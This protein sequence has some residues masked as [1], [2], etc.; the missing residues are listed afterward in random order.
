MA[1]DVFKEISSR[2]HEQVAFFNFPEVGL[3]AIVGI[4]STALGPALGGCR[5]RLYEDE[6]KAI[7]DALRLSEGMSY[8]NS[9]AGMDLGGGKSVIIADPRMQQGRRELFLKFAECLNN[10][11]GRYITAE[12]MGTSVSDV[13]IMREKTKHICGIELSEGGSGDPSPWTARGVFLGIQAALEH[14]FGSADF[15][16]RKITV[17]GVG[18]V[19]YHT[20]KNL[21]EAG[22]EV[23]VTD[24]V[25]E[26]V[27]AVVKEFGVKAVGIEEIYDEEC[28]VYAPCAIGQTVNALTIGRLKCKI[29]AGAANN[30]LINESIYNEIIGKNILYCPDFAVNAGGVINVG[31]EYRPGG[32]NKEW[33]AQK[34][35]QIY[36]TTHKILEESKTRKK[37][38]EVVALEL[39]RERIARGAPQT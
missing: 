27:D 14:V 17:Q 18:H 23:V 22:A 10:L 25:K 24:T 32:W 8:K 37:F 9:L 21:V 29:I 39:A 26:A 33:V 11:M 6:S 19:G 3:K 13:M 38:T 28:D 2:G 36:H 15:A 12:D 31:A 4:H 16:K 34:V 7:D 20:V 35:D 5:M 30:Q 1:F